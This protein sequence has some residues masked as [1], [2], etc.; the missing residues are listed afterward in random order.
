[1]GALSSIGALSSKYGI[2]NNCISQLNKEIKVK[3]KIKKI[4]D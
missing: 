1:M 3:R 4:S 2:S